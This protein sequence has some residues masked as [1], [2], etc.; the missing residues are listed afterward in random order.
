MKRTIF[1]IFLSLLCLAA[2]ACGSETTE[3]SASSAPLEASMRIEPAEPTAGQS[4]T[5]AV[6]VTQD[7]KAVDDAREVKFEWW[8][9]GDEKHVTIPAT[10]QKDGIY[11]AEQPIADPGSYFV[12]YHVT[13]RDF[14][15]MKKVPFTVTGIAETGAAHQHGGSSASSDAHASGVDIHFMPPEAISTSQTVPLIVHLMKDNE[16]FT[17]A[18][19]KFEVWQGNEK[20]HVFVDAAESQSGQYEASTSFPASGT[21]NVNV[22]V[23][24][25]DIHDHKAFTVAVP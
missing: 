13:A 2:T 24:K 5:F 25:A 10:L 23:E 3:T 19:V 14:H 22:H 16:V 21:Y 1:I 20:N 7:G 8:K 4:V 15:N 18:K 6:Q 11:T 9:D 17:E 12:Y